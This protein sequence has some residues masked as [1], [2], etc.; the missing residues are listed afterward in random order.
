MKS[1]PK[2]EQKS[3]VFFLPVCHGKCIKL[4][5]MINGISKNKVIR[6]QNSMMVSD[7]KFSFLGFVTVML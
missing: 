6:V 2:C 7:E 3:A 5:F 4:Q 1:I